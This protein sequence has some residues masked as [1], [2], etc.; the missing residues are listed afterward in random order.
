MDDL[1]TEM[2]KLAKKFN[3]GRNAHTPEKE[4]RK[5]ITVILNGKKLTGPVST[6][7]DKY[8]DSLKER[9]PNWIQD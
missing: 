9:I 3:S 4:D 2:E 5:H 7:R 8:F 6:E 1:V